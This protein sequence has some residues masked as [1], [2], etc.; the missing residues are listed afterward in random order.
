MHCYEIL[1]FI[2]VMR[3]QDYMQH[4]QNDQTYFSNGI[5]LHITNMIH[6]AYEKEERVM[7]IY[8]LYM[9][10]YTHICIYIYTYSVFK[11]GQ[12]YQIQ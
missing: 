4:I 2:N 5:I 10:I 3:I 1:N 11:V 7:I 6:N 8:I 9:H 12:H